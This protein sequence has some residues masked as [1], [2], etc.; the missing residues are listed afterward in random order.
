MAFKNTT[1][2]CLDN[3]GVKKVKCIKVYSK[4][5][6]EPGALI[7]VTLKDVMPHRKVKKGQ[8]YKAVVVR[9][10]KS[11]SRIYNFNVF[12]FTNSIV[13]LKKN[14]LVPLGTRI[15]GSVYF[16]I[17]SKGY[18]KIVLLSSFLV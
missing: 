18:M 16:E 17:R 12:Y 7:L 14:E 5:I 13:L 10:K 4:D 2:F 1:F 3:T 11:F 8:L 6:I 9:L 15:Y